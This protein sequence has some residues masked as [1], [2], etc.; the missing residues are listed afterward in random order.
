LVR[1]Y[2]FL[3][4][5]ERKYSIG[6]KGGQKMPKKTKPGDKKPRPLS[7]AWLS[8]QNSPYIGKFA[9]LI[10]D[11]ECKYQGTITR[12]VLENGIFLCYC[13]DLFRYDGSWN[14]IE[15]KEERILFRAVTLNN[16]PEDLGGG[17][18]K[19]ITSN[20]R[21]AYFQIEASEM[22]LTQESA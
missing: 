4:N 16:Q 6:G 22:A 2:Y 11:P 13:T 17:T 10:W 21:V 9:V 18:I 5:I 20:D 8:G 15:K 3:T 7:W 1:K 19:I 12:L 14:Q